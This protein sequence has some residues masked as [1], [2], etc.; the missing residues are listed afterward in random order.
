[1]QFLVSRS[2]WEGKR[3]ESVLSR[4]VQLMSN[5]RKQPQARMHLLSL[6][7]TG[8]KRELTAAFLD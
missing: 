3:H 8:V 1:M 5:S 2:V 7:A 4:E 6:G